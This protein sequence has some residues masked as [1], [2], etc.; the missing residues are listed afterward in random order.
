MS[1]S[2]RAVRR[3]LIGT[4][5]FILLLSG[6][7]AMAQQKP[8]GHLIP[9]GGGYADIYA[10]FSKEAVA[11]A[12]DKQVNILV[13][14]MAYSTNADTITAEERTT[15]LRDAEERRFQIEEACKRAAP[16]DFT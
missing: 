13:L 1:C 16:S 4:I 9:I 11:N 2:Y 3:I 15:N 8:I 12:K 6:L 5:V 7:P 14:P 10:G